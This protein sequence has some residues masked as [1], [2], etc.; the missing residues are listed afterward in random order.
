MADETRARPAP[1]ASAAAPA[2]AI[3]LAPLEPTVNDTGR[4]VETGGG[5]AT[6]APP[7]LLSTLTADAVATGVG[8]EPGRTGVSRRVDRGTV[9]GEGDEGADGSG[10][11]DTVGDCG[12][13]DVESS[14]RT[15][16]VGTEAPA[17]ATVVAAS[18]SSS[19]RPS[20][21]AAAGE[22]GAVPGDDRE[23]DDI[24]VGVDASTTA[25]STS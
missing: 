24:G 8:D 12:S 10:G 21:D 25:A 1:E 13:V 2:L 15:L 19:S 6:P 7:P 18:S 3:V 22:A 9:G 5:E 20:D 23:A 11:G 17:P 16:D 14:L 4:G